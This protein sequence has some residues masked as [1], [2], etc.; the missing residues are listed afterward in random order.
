MFDCII[1][2][3]RSKVLSELLSDQ[4]ELKEETNLQSQLLKWQNQDIPVRTIYR[5]YKPQYP[6]FLGERSLDCQPLLI[7]SRLHVDKRRCKCGSP[8]TA[9]GRQ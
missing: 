1:R 3:P 4:D 8:C 9:L 7:S 2:T 5:V 6:Q